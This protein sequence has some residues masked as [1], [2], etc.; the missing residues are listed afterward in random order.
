[1]LLSIE[2]TAQD[3]ARQKSPIQGHLIGLTCGYGYQLPSGNHILFNG[4]SYAVR[5]GSIYGLS[6]TAV[7]GPAFSRDYDRPFFE[8]RI[9]VENKFTLLSQKRVRPVLLLGGHLGTVE[10]IYINGG[11]DTEHRHKIVYGFNLG[12][13]LEVLFG[14]RWLAAFYPRF[15]FTL[16][17]SGALEPNFHAQP[18]VAYRWN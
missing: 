1:M 3:R 2:A 10:F 9:F 6:F 5:L 16:G 17:N 11:G 18:M 7:G 13:G 14:Q 15:Y 8:S 4:L 12:A